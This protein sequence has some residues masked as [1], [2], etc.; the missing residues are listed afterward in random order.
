MVARNG[1]GRPFDAGC[2][3][4]DQAATLVAVPSIPRGVFSLQPV[5]YKGG[6]MATRTMGYRPKHGLVSAGIRGGFVPVKANELLT[7]WRLYADGRIELRDLRLWLA[8]LELRAESCF[9]GPILDEAF[10]GIRLKELTTDNRSC[11]SIAK[12]HTKVG[13]M[14]QDA[15]AQ[16]MGSVGYF[17]NLR[18]RVPLPRRL[19]RHLAMNGSRATI[20]A[21]V[22][23]LLRCL[24]WRGEAC[25]SGGTAKAS[26]LA[27]ELGVSLR[28]IRRGRKQLIEQ[29]WLESVAAPQHVLNRHG[30]VVRVR[31]GNEKNSRLSPPRPHK[32]VCLAPPKNRDQLRCLQRT[33]TMTSANPIAHQKHLLEDRGFLEREFRKLSRDQLL[34]GSDAQHLAALSCAAYA[35]RIGDRSPVGLFRY[36]V[37]MGLW[38]RPTLRDEDAARRLFQSSEGPSDTTG[39]SQSKRPTPVNALTSG[40]LAQARILVK[41]TPLSRAHEEIHREHDTNTEHGFGVAHAQTGD[42]EQQGKRH[43]GTLP[44]FADLCQ[45]TGCRT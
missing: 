2:D 22:G 32:A 33:R 4:Q 5:I 13:V 27:D 1:P 34:D 45:V 17:R 14:V 44:H 29:G 43:A 24:Y 23:H 28:S 41:R 36:L 15:V 25:V 16:T 31:S 42:A 10:T 9:R 19:V 11:V 40:V 30:A 39:T 8:G 38:E 21:A 20:A 35:A 37:R 7:A 26:S 6:A 3:L 12:K 18:R